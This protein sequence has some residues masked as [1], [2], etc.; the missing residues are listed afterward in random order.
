MNETL[1]VV[2]KKKK[3]KKRAKFLLPRGSS[4][5]RPRSEA[6]GLEWS[7][8]YRCSMVYGLSR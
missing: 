7:E 6:V 3:K 5:L 2:D 1:G 8:L 4:G